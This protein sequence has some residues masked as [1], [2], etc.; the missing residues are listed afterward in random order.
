[1][2]L[3]ADLGVDSIKRVEILSAVRKAAPH[4]P[5][6]AARDLAALRTLGEVI[7]RLETATTTP[8][9][10]AVPAADVVGADPAAGVAPVPRRASG[11]AP[12]SRRAVARVAHPRPGVATSGL[13]DCRRLVVVDDGDGVAAAVAAALTAHGR[14]AEVVDGPD[15]AGGADG[16]VWLP[17]TSTDAV[18]QARD[19]VR[20]A[21]AV[22]PTARLFV[23]VQRTGGAF[24]GYGPSAGA[25]AL[26]RTAAHEW[27]E[28]TVRAL[29]VADGDVAGAIVDELLYG[30]DTLEVGCGAERCTLVDV[31]AEVDGDAP[32]LLRDGDVVLA[33]GGARGVT[34]TALRGLAAQARREGKTLR[35]AVVGR[36]VLVDE[37]DVV[38][39]GADDATL[40]RIL[41]AEHRRAGREVT[42][43]A[44][45]AEVGR[46]LASR[47]IRA[48][49]AA[50]GEATYLTADVTDRDAL[51]RAVR[52]AEEALGP[53]A[54]VVH[55]AGVLADRAIADKTDA[56]VERV[57]ATK[58]RGFEALLAATAHAPVR[59]VFVF[60]SVAARHG[61]AG[62]CDYA[63]ANEIVDR[64]G[65]ARARG[66]APPGGGGGGPSL[67]T[68]FTPSLPDKSSEKTQERGVG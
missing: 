9:L 60:S 55:G 52:D 22:A 26:A 50:L 20:Y 12:L 40:K 53:I 5:D 42:P 25:V 16:L 37:R 3:E 21:R 67:G 28:A 11:I 1:M 2:D 51:A 59:A 56:Q 24:D 4:L 65:G 47:E 8:P 6:V 32:S 31:D 66:G 19:A 49:V 13:R 63:M 36:S 62:Q 57:L 39:A 18:A 17:S 48:T 33:T 44:L 45:G 29:D 27:P 68:T 14:P 30:G 7:G 10:G 58:V 64:G 46:I 15:G 41:L 43:A 38:R 23:T 54:V 34:A 61:N 35:V